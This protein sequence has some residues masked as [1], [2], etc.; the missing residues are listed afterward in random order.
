M[1]I[2]NILS[3]LLYIL[4]S[5]ILINGFQYQK[6][7]NLIK[8]ISLYNN[9]NNNNNIVPNNQNDIYRKELT[10]SAITTFS[11]ILLTLGTKKQV[12][13][14]TYFDT[15]VYGDKELKIATLN[16]MKQK[17]RNAIQENPLLAPKFLQLSIIDAL[18][19]D[20]KSEDG[21]PDGSIKF[22]LE[23][24]ENKDLIE[25]SNVLEKIR[26]DL[27]RTNTVGYADL[28]SFGGGEALESCGCPRTTVQV[29]RFDSKGPNKKVFNFNDNTAESFYQAGLEPKDVAL[30]I[31]ALGEVQRIAQATVDFRANKKSNDED[32]DEDDNWQGN[33]PST[34]GRRDEIYGK[35]LE[36]NDFGSKFLNSVLKGKSDL[37]YSSCLTDDSKVK[38]FTSKYATNDKA[39]K[40]DVVAAYLKL[41]NL[42]ESYNDL[43][44]GG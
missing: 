16:K 29:G 21:G 39:F 15:D 36:I 28:V 1:N 43:R 19:Y 37:K 25:A 8:K 2:F 38:V 32:E 40:E 12:N 26:N 4:I 11:T 20:F 18:G 22:E 27:K 10:K 42:G 6:T 44:R 30:L 31:G 35:K 14:K 7:S 5:I 41:T 34:F 13:A 24:E 23:K 9:N 3:L 17:L 33:V